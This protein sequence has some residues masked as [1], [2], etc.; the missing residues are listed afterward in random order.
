MK[1]ISVADETLEDI[2]RNLYK[3]SAM[4]NTLR[5]AIVCQDYTSFRI[6]DCDIE[7]ILELVEDITRQQS[8]KILEHI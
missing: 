6:D 2:N 8:F 5:M 4:V 1:K 3:V 7:I